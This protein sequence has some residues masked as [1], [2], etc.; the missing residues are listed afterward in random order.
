VPEIV[1]T[2][3]ESKDH[4]TLSPQLPL[5]DAALA[6]PAHAAANTRSTAVI[7]KRDFRDSF[8][9]HAN[10]LKDKRHGL[11]NADVRPD[12]VFVIEYSFSITDVFG[13]N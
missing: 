3:D 7:V 13:I 11:S 5:G 9:C 1:R 10:P 4:C 8:R 12:G 2:P 6:A